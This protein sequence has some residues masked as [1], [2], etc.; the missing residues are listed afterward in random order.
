VFVAGNGLEEG[1]AMDEAA[2]M[3]RGAPSVLVEVCCQVVVA[4]LVSMVQA[5]IGLRERTV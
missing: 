4:T 3:E 2:E 5:S 1:F